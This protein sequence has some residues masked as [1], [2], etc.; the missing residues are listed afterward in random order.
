MY[1]YC[2][3]QQIS[4]HYGLNGRKLVRCSAQVR[5]VALAV[6]G[7]E[8]CEVHCCVD[9]CG[10]MRCCAVSCLVDLVLDGAVLCMLY[11]CAV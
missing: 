11:E 4:E 5:H 9:R 1:V 2:R 7:A 8:C 10:A 6:F 3:T